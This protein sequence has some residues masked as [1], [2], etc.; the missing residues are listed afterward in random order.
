[1]D[2]LR[3]F[4]VDSSWLVHIKPTC[5]LIARDYIT[6]FKLACNP[7]TDVC[8]HDRE[9]LEM[10]SHTRTHD[11]QACLSATAWSS[12]SYSPCL[13]DFQH[14][15]DQHS[16]VETWQ[17]LPLCCLSSERITVPMHKPIKP[18]GRSPEIFYSQ[19]ECELLG[20]VFYVGSCDRQTL[21]SPGCDPFIDLLVQCNT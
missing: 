2:C 19:R 21:I 10:S 7:V 17:L 3:A 6:R 20:M 13:A 15:F 9:A 18:P 4:F 5:S 16:L 12:Q 1:M 8:E 14:K 11:C